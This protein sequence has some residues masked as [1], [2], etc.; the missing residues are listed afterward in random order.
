MEL[1]DIDGETYRVLARGATDDHGRVYLHLASESRSVEQKNGRRPAQ[2]A[3][4]A[5]LARIYGERA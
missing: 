5:D 3:D 2:I 1:I 4:W